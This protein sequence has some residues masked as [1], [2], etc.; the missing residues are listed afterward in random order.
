MVLLDWFFF[1]LNHHMLVAY[2]GY[3]GKVPAVLEL[4]I[5]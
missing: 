3:L 2:K 5:Q 4:S 1:V